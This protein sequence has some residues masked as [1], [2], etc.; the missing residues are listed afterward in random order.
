MA[1]AA[2]AF[3]RMSTGS[4]VDI[5]GTVRITASEVVGAEVLPAMLAELRVQYPQ[6]RFEIHLS[7]HTEDLLRQDADIAVRMVKP[8]HAALIMKYVGAVKLGLFAAPSYIAADGAPQSLAELS[9]FAIIGPDRT[10]DELRVLTAI[11][12]VSPAKLLS[13]RTDS[14]LAQLAAIR[15]GVGIGICQVALAK[16][17]PELVRLLDDEF[18]HPLESWVVMHEDLRRVPRIRATFDQLVAK[19][20]VYCAQN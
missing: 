20:T 12:G 9:R 19:L 4:P 13:Y 15:A 3:A 10:P 6:L 7:N 17:Q 2:A 5:T 18:D 1:S 14:H 16:R 11:F 8:E